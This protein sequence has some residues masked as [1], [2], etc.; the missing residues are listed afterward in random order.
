MIIYG[1]EH[2]HYVPY[3]GV[4][5]VLNFLSVSAPP[6]DLE[7]IGWQ[8]SRRHRATWVPANG[9]SYISLYLLVSGWLLD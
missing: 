4:L 5:F 1:P 8:R 9:G 2:Q 3:V 7:S 6:G